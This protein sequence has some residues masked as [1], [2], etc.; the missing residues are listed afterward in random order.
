M[1]KACESIYRQIGQ[2]INPARSDCSRPV[3]IAGSKPSLRSVMLG[4]LQNRSPW[5]K[6]S[7]P[8]S[9]VQRFEVALKVREPMLPPLSL[10]DPQ[11]VGCC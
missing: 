1:L 8:F 9:T 6:E 5:G 7:K 3:Q 10:S 11:L 4:V 2:Q